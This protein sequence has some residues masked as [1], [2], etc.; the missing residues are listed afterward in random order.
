MTP[1][2]ANPELDDLIADIIV[3][4]HDHDEALIGYENA[5]GE[6]DCFPCL[7][8]V[9]DHDIEIQSVAAANGRQE[10]IATCHHT[11]AARTRSPYATSTSTPTSP[12]HACSPPTATG[13][14]PKTPGPEQL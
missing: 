1:S 11:P 14:A 3:D 4:A 12:P 8:T 13:P 6:A 9:I 2:R 7:A 5:F 10:L